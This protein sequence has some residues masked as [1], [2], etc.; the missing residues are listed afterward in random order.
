MIYV[1]STRNGGPSVTQYD[2]MDEA[3]IETLMEDIGHTDIEFITEEE[4]NIELA[5]ILAA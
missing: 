4:Y 1:K 3:T 5:A 2:G